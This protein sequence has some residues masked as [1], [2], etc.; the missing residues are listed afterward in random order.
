MVG[1]LRSLKADGPSLRPG[2][3]F[4]FSLCK[5]RIIM[6]DPQLMVILSIRLVNTARAMLSQGF[7]VTISEARQCSLCLI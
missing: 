7:A 5:T 2:Q 6:I 4:R 3:G 1:K